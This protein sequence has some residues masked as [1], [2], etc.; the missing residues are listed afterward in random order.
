[1]SRNRAWYPLH[2]ID[3]LNTSLRASSSSLEL[4]QSNPLFFSAVTKRATYC[5]NV[6][7]K[8]YRNDQE[9]ENSPVV[10]RLERP[11]KFQS[12][13]EFIKSHVIALSVGH[14]S[15]I[16]SIAGNGTLSKDPE[17]GELVVNPF[18]KTDNKKDLRE[19]LLSGDEVKFY[20]EI[21]SKKI[22]IE[23]NELFWVY[24]E[25]PHFK[26]P[27]E[28]IGKGEAGIKVFDVNDLRLEADNQLTGM[29]GGMGVVSGGINTANGIE[30]ATDPE[31]KKEM[32]ERL[33]F[34][35]GVGRGR[36]NWIVTKSAFQLQQIRQVIKDFDLTAGNDRD[37]RQICNVFNIPENLLK[38]NDTYENQEQSEIRYY[39]G[40]I[41]TTMQALADCLAM[42]YELPKNERI[43]ASFDHIPV[44]QRLKVQRAEYLNTY[45]D[46]L[47]KAA[48][49]NG[50]PEVITNLV[51]EAL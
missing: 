18:V 50:D 23:N 4:F 26:N 28:A 44:M 12:K 46:A 15:F 49:L 32:E 36:S 2:F 31:D 19:L 39:Q 11:N 6:L 48:N 27:F 5:S 3:L 37:I 35:Y 10:A 17:V 42:F 7:F 41:Q 16:N 14:I 13:S 22:P 9:V 29:S 45:F 8:H 1:M 21:D 25:T 51:N 30:V 47:N 34:K 43:E 20:Y 40:D 24:D 38:G 33:Q